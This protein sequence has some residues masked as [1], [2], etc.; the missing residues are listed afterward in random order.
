MEGQTV[1]GSVS[2]VRIDGRR[3]PEF[4]SSYS[5]KLQSI[6]IDVL[7]AHSRFDMLFNEELDHLLTMCKPVRFLSVTARP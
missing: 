7:P 5:C 1:G 3:E 4:F 6:A 2:D